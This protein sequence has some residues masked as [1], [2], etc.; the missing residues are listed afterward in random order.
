[1]GNVRL[2]QMDGKMPNIA[3]MKLAH[4]H[5]SQGDRVVLTTSVQRSLFEP[6][7]YDA[8]YASAIFRRSR[9]LVDELL[10]AW[11]G[12]VAGG[13]GTWE[14]PPEEHPDVPEAVREAVRRRHDMEQELTEITVEEHLGLGEYEHYDYGIYPGYPWSMGFTQRGCRLNCSF[15]V[16][17]RKEGRPVALNSIMDIWRP[18][19]E[20]NIV[21]LDNDFFG[22]PKD[23]WKARIQELREGGF[24]VSFNQGINI[25]LIDDESA[26]E[27]SRLRYYDHKFTRRRLYTAW[28]NLGQER[29]FF[30]G[31]EKLTRAGIPPHHL[32]VYMLVGFAEG[33]TMEE[34]MHRYH[35]IR[36]AGCMPF[37]MVYGEEPPAPEPGDPDQ[38]EMLEKRRRHLDLKRFQRWVIQRYDQVVPWENFQRS[39]EDAPPGPLLEA[40]DL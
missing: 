32:M 16:V 14:D 27:I 30:R 9:P 2:V 19:T 40:G 11:P 17:P 25:R 22:Q 13:T 37:P 39:R 38:D 6:D 1:M 5:R 4:W 29:V 36:D 23:D 8:V 26:Q 3:L 15:C 35:G 28:D 12:A 20:R 24:R 7:R 33:E 31:L 10:A 34:V 21:L 18:G